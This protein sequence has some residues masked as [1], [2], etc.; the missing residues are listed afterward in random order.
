MPR[1]LLAVLIAVVA[2]ILLA[3]P[4][5]ACP[6]C[7]AEGQ[8]LTK[9]IN[10]ASLVIVGSIYKTSGGL[11]YA[12]EGST[13]FIVD[14]VVKRHDILDKALHKPAELGGKEAL[15][16]GRAIPLNDPEKKFKY[17]VFCDVFK[18]KID[19]YRLMRVEAS[20]DPSKYLSGALEV[21]DKAAPERLKFFFKYLDD[22]ETEIAADAYKE[23]AY[24]DYKDYQGMA[25]D[26]PADKI[27]GWINDQNTATF[28]LGLYASL[29]GHCG[30]PKHA[31]VL[32]KLLDD[33]A[34]RL[35]AGV[36]GIMAG[37]ILLNKKDGW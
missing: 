37:Y 1:C 31:D 3:V 24:A 2:V 17:V 5:D 16:L 6:F 20:S 26:L 8:T 7:N 14:K 21:K 30:T 15:T 36:D 22:P 18:G 34:R 13:E 28:R 35:T 11:D 4:S 23:F 27:A 32:H 29:L 12:V 25:K 33:P 19:P 9:E 10:L